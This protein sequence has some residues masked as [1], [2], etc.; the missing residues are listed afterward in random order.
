MSRT[1]YVF[2][3]GAEHTTARYFARVIA[4]LDGWQ[5]VYLDALFDPALL[6]SD[7]ILFYVDP[8]PAWPLGMESLPCLTVAYLI[9]VHQGLR[10]RLQ[11]SQF[12]D[13]VFIAQKEFVPAFQQLGH[14]HAYWLPL[15]CDAEIHNVGSKS[16]PYDLGFVGNIGMRGTKRFE[17]L[18]TVLPKYQTNDYLKY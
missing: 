12:F 6:G 5:C 13:A 11:I 18:S 14:Q 9:D 8:A 16:R 1:V 10:S 4:A 2:S 17:I 3:V 15:A 7:D